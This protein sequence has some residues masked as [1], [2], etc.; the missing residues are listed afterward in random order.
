YNSGTTYLYI[1]KSTNSSD[2]SRTYWTSIGSLDV[3]GVS[4]FYV[5][6]IDISEDGIMHGAY[7]FGS[8]SHYYYYY[9]DF[10]L[11]D[12]TVLHH[13]A[14][15]GADATYTATQPFVDVWVNPEGTKG[16]YSANFNNTV[17][18]WIRDLS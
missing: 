15:T 7:V 18:V 17:C 14:I 16:Y 11:N 4:P 2:L 5:G 10:N 12:N 13:N 1:Y 8:S 6:S 9:F 3:S